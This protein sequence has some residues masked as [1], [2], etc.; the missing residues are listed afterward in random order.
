[1]ERLSKL[2]FHHLTRNAERVEQGQGCSKYPP[3]LKNPYCRQLIYNK[4]GFVISDFRFKVSTAIWSVTPK[5]RQLNYSQVISKYISEFNQINLFLMWMQITIWQL[6]W[7]KKRSYII[8]EA[9]KVIAYFRWKTGI[10]LSRTETYQENF[11][12]KI[13]I[14]LHLIREIIY[15]WTTGQSCLLLLFYTVVKG[16]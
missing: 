6:L 3:A 1:M 16:T 12:S 11:F 13:S 9:A 2:G 7:N 8:R 14:F 10:N 15:C 4:L 5:N